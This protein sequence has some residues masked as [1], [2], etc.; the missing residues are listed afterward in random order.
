[1]VP[2]FENACIAPAATGSSDV[3]LVGVTGSAGRLDA[4]IVNLA[5]LYAPSA[6]FIAANVDNVA[7]TALAQRGCYP[8]TNTRNDPNSPVLMQQFGILSYTTHVY[9][10][11]TITGPAYFTNATFVSPK[12][13]SLSPAVDGTNWFTALMN[14]RT[15]T[16]DSRWTGIRWH[17]DWTSTGRG[18][19]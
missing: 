13:F 14:K 8:F 12:M 3:W 6:K 19:R 10:N 4:Y 2:S 16:T 9:P 15:T 11:G 7:W 18:T 5:N 17:S 1:S